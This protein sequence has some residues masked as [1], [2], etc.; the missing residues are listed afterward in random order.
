MLLATRG[1]ALDVARLAAL[2]GV[3]LRRSVV[4]ERERQEVQGLHGVVTVTYRRAV[5]ELAVTWEHDGQTLTRVVAAPVEGAI[6]GDAA[7][8]AGNLAREQVDEL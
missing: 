1:D 6:E 8:L 5:G 2:L 4:L 3:E 7:M